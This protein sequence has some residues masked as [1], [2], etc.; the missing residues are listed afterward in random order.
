MSKIKFYIIVFLFN[1][2]AFEVFAQKDTVAII[3]SY[4]SGKG[5]MMKWVTTSPQV[6]FA[7]FKNGYNLYR[8]EVLKTPN[9]GEKLADYVKL[10]ENLIM[11]WSKEKLQTEIQS[12]SN[13]KQASMFIANVEN[14]LTRPK[15]GNQKQSLEVDQAD[16]FL[17]L[18]SNFI[19]INNNNIA[20]A[21]GVFFIDNTYA[22]DK[23]YVYKIEIPTQKQF[24]SYMI[25]YPQSDKSIEKVMGFSV[26]LEKQAA[27]LKWFNNDN[28]TYPY[29]NIYRST[30][31]DKGYEKLNKLPYV[32]NIGNAIKNQ[33]ITTFIDS[34]PEYN[35]TYYYKVVG[36]NAFEEEGAFSE[37]VELKTYYLIQNFPQIIKSSSPDNKT[38]KIEWT[39]DAKDKPY[40]KGFNVR[41]SISGDAV[42]TRINTQLLDN[43]TYEYSDARSKGSSNYYSVCA[44][45]FSGD[46]TCSVVKSHLLIDSVP[47]TKPEIVF[48]VCD[49]NGVLTIKWKK[50]IEPDMLGYRIFKTY[51]LKKEPVRVIS[52]HT[53]DTTFTEKLNLKEP[54]NKI[55][56]RISAIDQHFNPSVAS[57]YFE[58]KIPDKIPPINGYFE[59][60]SV[61]MNGITL[62]WNK[63][64]AYD[65]KRMYIYKKSKMDVQ[66]Q[67]LLKLE[68][69]SLNTITTYTDTSTKSN[70]KY[71]YVLVTEDESGL[72]SEFSKP[73]VAEQVNKDKIVAVT[74]FQG[75]V[76]KENKMI[77]LLWEYPYKAKG[78]KIY[79]AKDG[80]PLTTYEFV[81][82]DKREF[83]DKWLTPNTGYTYIIVAEL[84]GG[85][86]SGFSK[87]LE[88]K[89]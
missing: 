34:F 88:L 73:V 11:H 71:A 7:G 52:G 21:M 68:G 72:F 51:S 70:E 81:P 75:I 86:T 15:K 38:I 6:F 49:T 60:Y 10:N 80:D 77:K 2:L 39:I 18:L 64:N 53:A 48:G 27:Y 26:K 17:N 28:A 58:V 89:Y 50:N 83:Y 37:I 84:E 62:K 29:Y 23:K 31:K 61:G 41:Y 20:S 67:K 24:T 79:R 8:A 59:T 74:N 25:L 22:A 85:Y 40:I 45:G 57:T 46:S 9:S 14:L 82:G 5:L 43:K 1:V 44:Y 32:G 55:Y 76:A 66:Y 63:S 78:F 30:N 87:K 3:S 12:D 69:D 54:Y 56:Y 35:K 47:P 33:N 19:S 13:L 36:I 65:L 16:G 4:K 42:P